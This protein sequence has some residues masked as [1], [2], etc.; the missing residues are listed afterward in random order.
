WTER[1]A[2]RPVRAGRG[3]ARSRAA[4]R[5]LPRRSAARS[6]LVEQ[7]GEI[8][9]DGVGAVRAQRIGLTDAV[10][11]D[12]EAEAPGVPGLHSGERVL[13]DRGLGRLHPERAGARQIGVRRRLALQVLALGHDAVDPFLEVALDPR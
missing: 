6:R 13:E 9:H 5:A 7:F 4:P 8:P 11:A 2:T 10:D 1:R 3:R 12:D